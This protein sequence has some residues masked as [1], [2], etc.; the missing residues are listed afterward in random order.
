MKGGSRHHNGVLFVL[1]WRIH[2]NLFNQVGGILW[3]I[4]ASDARVC[5]SPP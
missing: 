1:G 3:S 5:S 2:L 4:V